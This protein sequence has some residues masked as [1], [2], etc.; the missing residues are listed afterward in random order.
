[1]TVMELMYLNAQEVCK[2]FGNSTLDYP[3]IMSISIH[4]ILKVKR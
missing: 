4:V 1:M 3:E 2:Y